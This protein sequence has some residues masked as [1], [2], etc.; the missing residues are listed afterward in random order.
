MENFFEKLNNIKKH[1][2]L[3]E[4]RKSEIRRHLTA[5]IFSDGRVRDGAHIRHKSQR[6]LIFLFFKKPMH[7]LII[8][9][10][11]AAVGGGTTVAAQ[12]TVPGDI[13]YPVKVG[14]TEKVGSA[15]NFSAEGKALYEADLAD[16]RLQE[17][18]AVTVQ[19]GADSEVRAQLE[20]RFDSHA[21]GV[22]EKIAKFE[23]EGDV[24]VASSI[25]SKFESVL[26]A[27]NKV[28][29]EIQGSR[30]DGDDSINSITDQVH[31]RLEAVINTRS[32]LEGRVTTEAS[33]DSK[34][35]A[36][37]KINA[38]KNVIA[39]LKAYVSSRSESFS[40]KTNDDIE[41]RIKA[42]QD[43]LSDARA[44]F[45]EEAYGTAFNLGNRA[46]RLAQEARALAQT[47]LKIEAT[48]LLIPSNSPEVDDK[49]E[50]EDETENNRGE[51][52]IQGN[53]KRS[54]GESVDIEGNLDLKLNL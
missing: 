46:I 36:E 13:L 9:A 11:V 17:I 32:S 16:R 24:Y 37:G 18:E 3:D 25:A 52:N 50:M 44:Q 21:K 23:S 8:V 28:L 12:N 33:T 19:G 22:E 30:E 14:F 47:R 26:K 29:I 31:D 40:D 4:T 6:S 45:S 2:R 53:I 5:Y 54:S 39:S 38:A 42:S 10:L 20:T 1:V 51:T 15:L 48:I 34:Q 27:H 7:I 49:N 43:A 35:A 41:I